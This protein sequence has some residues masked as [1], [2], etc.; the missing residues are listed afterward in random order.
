MCEFVLLWKRDF[1]L[2]LR[3][4]VLATK[5]RREQ[6]MFK[7]IVKLSLLLV[8]L[9]I[10]ISADTKTTSNNLP[11]LSNARETGRLKSNLLN[12]K[13]QKIAVS[14]LAP[15]ANLAD[16]NKIIGPLFKNKCQACHGPKKVKGGF[17]IDELD[18]NLLNGKDVAKWLEVYEVLSNSEMPPDD[19]PDYHLNDGDRSKIVDWLGAEI[20]K[21]SQVRRN[22]KGH[23]SFRR[24]ARYEYNHAL[25]DLLGLPYDFVDRLVTETVSEDGFKNSS[26][27][28]KMTAEQFQTYKDIG[29]Q[30]LKK[31]TVTGAQPKPL[32][33][34]VPMADVIEPWLKKS[35]HPKY[36]DK[37]TKKSKI[38]IFNKKDADYKN[39]SKQQHVVNHQTG[40]LIILHK[41]GNRNKP[42]QSF[43][44][45]PKTARGIDSPKPVALVLK[46]G[47]EFQLNFSNSLPDEGIMR[48]SIRASRTTVN[49]NEYVSLRLLF[50]AQTSNNANF[51][52]VIS[53]RDMPVTALPDKPQMIHFEIPLSEIR[54]N[55]FRKNKEKFPSRSEL[56]RLKVVSNNDKA[57]NDQDALS[58]I[59]DHIEVSAP[60]YEQWPPKSHTALFID[61]KNKNNE[62]VYSREILSKF[63]QRCW[64]RPA[65][66]EE[67]DRY[68]ALFNKYRP[69]FESFE[70]TMLE[71]L[72]TVL[73]S[74]EFL[75][76]NQIKETA[77]TKS[78]GN[79][80]DLELA[81]RLSFFL[82]SSLP[83]Q[84]LIKLAEQKKLKDPEVL[85]AQVKRMLAD[86]RGER[87]SRNFVQQWLGLDGIEN[88]NLSKDLNGD[89]RQAMLKE[90]VAFFNEVL[91]S[92]RSIMDFIHSDYAMINEDL[93][94][95][96]KIPGV[97]GPYFR[98]VAVTSQNNRGGILTNAIISTMNANGKESNPLKRG[99]WLLEHI[100]NDPPPPPPPN[101]PEVDL[102]D[103]EILKMTL[104]EQIE[105]H[106]DKPACRSCHAKI[107]P[108]GIAFE[109]YD[110]LGA[111]RS[112]INK[113]P[114]DATST[115]FNKQELAGMDGLKRY[116]LSARQDQFTKAFVHKMLTYALGRPLSFSDRSDV[117]NLSIELRKNG[118]RLGSLVSIIVNSKIF[119]S[120]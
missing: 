44:P 51:M 40:E 97:Y 48:V 95:H 106:R 1:L 74:P 64:R 108:W 46:N 31:A 49:K 45:K 117:E 26:E 2:S 20:A 111:F 88:V 99:I 19:E 119:Q 120:K 114:V 5:S 55:P 8:I 91:Q 34:S 24:M 9:P 50:G 87:F 39:I 113:K 62:Q 105:N 7:T 85:N 35:K 60:Y 47:H 32:Y 82:W 33:Y 38:E 3:G 75:Y 77:E 66:A 6:A 57:N 80:N 102:T 71:V 36:I 109:N 98:K 112:Q 94:R 92:N 17:R 15:T 78:G 76:L 110:A 41:K 104:K 72:A 81:N 79:V 10:S 4:P 56:M 118:D 29:L 53:N 83:D 101:V 73:A 90:P 59:I 23:S 89:L 65:N 67:I 25:Q 18:A 63:I 86:E 84:T 21:A 22:E 54:R 70:E 61:S 93:A 58:V 16:F 69:Q 116:L 13:D 27:H 103:P 42:S 96:Y 68:A 37:E 52:E 11:S 107:D 28:L 100:L 12:T 30:A 115:L 14:N 43:S